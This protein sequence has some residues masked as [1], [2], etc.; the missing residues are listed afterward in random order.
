M[1]S[2]SCSWADPEGGCRGSG[3]PPPEKSQKIEFLCNTSR[4]PLKN[5]VATKPAFKVWPS[6]ARQRNAI[7]MTFHRRADDGLFIAVL[8]PLS[9][10]QLKKGI[11]FGPPLTKL[12]GSAIVAHLSISHFYLKATFLNTLRCNSLCRVQY[13][14]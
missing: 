12:S 7:S 1:D 14:Q 10:H 11:K 8:D 13:N 2:F 5:H 6:S 3:P 4:D 9:P